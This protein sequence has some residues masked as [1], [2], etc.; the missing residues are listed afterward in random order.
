MNQYFK[1]VVSIS[2][3]NQQNN[4]T[5]VLYLQAIHSIPTY[6]SRVYSISRFNSQKFFDLQSLK[7]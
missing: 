4:T 6:F 5:H 1:P 2:W 3:K 7:K